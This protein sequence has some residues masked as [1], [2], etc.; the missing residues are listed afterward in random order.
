[1]KRNKRSN[2]V[3]YEAQLS[4]PEGRWGMTL[5]IT[6]GESTWTSPW[7]AFQMMRYQTFEEARV[8]AAEQFVALR[9]TLEGETS[10]A[11]IDQ[12]GV[13]GKILPQEGAWK[14]S[15]GHW[16]KYEPPPAWPP[17]CAIEGCDAAEIIWIEKD[18][19]T[20][21]DW[22]P[23]F[24]YGSRGMLMRPMTDGPPWI[25]PEGHKPRS[26]HTRMEARPAM[27]PKP[28]L[29]DVAKE[30][31]ERRAEWRRRGWPDAHYDDEDTCSCPDH[32]AMRVHRREEGDGG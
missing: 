8:K 17:W 19:I 28:T 30:L 15:E 26:E 21:K 3:F 20:S 7:F 1:M 32:V 23:F 16:F 31:L 13:Y 12:W 6:R 24:P 14:C 11:K 5:T 9:R 22:P 18:D 27:P 2:R 4:C 29:S 10:T 25:W